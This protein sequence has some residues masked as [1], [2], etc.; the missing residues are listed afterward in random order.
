MNLYA[1]PPPSV[2][3]LAQNRRQLF[4]YFKTKLQILGFGAMR[5]RVLCGRKTV[6]EIPDT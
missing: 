2:E 1:V 5:E 4:F 6:E 3:S